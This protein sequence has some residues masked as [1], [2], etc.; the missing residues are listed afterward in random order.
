M[1][2]SFCVYKIIHAVLHRT[3][4]LIRIL[5]NCPLFLW[6]RLR[7]AMIC[8]HLLLCLQNSS[9]QSHGHSVHKK[10]CKFD[11]TFAYHNVQG[12]INF[13]HPLSQIDHH[14]CSLSLPLSLVHFPRKFTFPSFVLSRGNLNKNF[15]FT[16]NDPREIEGELKKGLESSIHIFLDL[17]SFKKCCC[18]Y[19]VKT[20]DW[21]I[22]A[23]VGE[24][25]S[26]C[27]ATSTWRWRH[28][29]AALS[30]FLG[31]WLHL[32]MIIRVPVPGDFPHSKHARRG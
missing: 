23:I 30:I 24:C 4:F 8:L 5:L 6:I 18:L 16:W 12:C 3:P 1:T 14:F 7:R 29:A 9:K 13:L 19:S 17:T 27:D 31:E 10:L 2:V 20:W 15:L 22:E 32:Q 11:P 28:L 21:F 25:N 26:F